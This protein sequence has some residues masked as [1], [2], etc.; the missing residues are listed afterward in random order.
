MTSFSV[1]SD[2]VIESARLNAVRQVMKTY[3]ARFKSV[4]EDISA[5][6]GIPEPVIIDT[7]LRRLM[8][9]LGEGHPGIIGKAGL[10]HFFYAIASLAW[11]AI[12][13]LVSVIYPK[14]RKII[15]V[16]LLLDY[17]GADNFIFYRAVLERLNPHKGA[18][19]SRKN[20]KVPGYPDE[21]N[22]IYRPVTGRFGRKAALQALFMLRK[23]FRHISLQD[24]SFAFLYVILVR[25]IARYKTDV[26]G[27]SASVFY[28]SGDNYFGGIRYWIYRNNGIGSIVLIQNALRGG[29]YSETYL[30]ADHYF[31][32]GRAIPGQIGLRAVRFYP[33][34][35]M[36]T[37]LT[38]MGP[39]RNEKKFDIVFIEQIVEVNYPETYNIW[40]YNAVLKNMVR[41]SREFPELKICFATRA[42]RENRQGVASAN[43]SLILGSPMMLSTEIGTTSYQAMMQSCLVV[44]YN[45]TMGF[46]AA[47]VGIPFI[48]CN[49]DRLA[50]LP[51]ED[52][53]SVLCDQSY[54]K[55]KERV[56]RLLNSGPE[57]T[58]YI[59]RMSDEYLAS[60]RDVPGE[61]AS[62]IN[63]LI[64]DGRT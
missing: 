64:I 22:I 57:L 23:I 34:G 25:K 54:D 44:T 52:D 50:F 2:L 11:L 58:Q 36:K 21:M 55:F 41:F 13:C 14:T 47:S 4:A 53:L 24:V 29:M 49:Y 30:Y 31:G 28:S 18:I 8:M 60:D 12:Q 32:F 27:L 42:G 43:E 46:E 5:D 40:A 63:G 16:D 20:G 62:V 9:D 17:W 15:K 35:S 56:W 37:W 33:I 39:E 48:Y 45:S 59:R 61:I 10:R 26:D 6:S 1:Y 51:P 19:F 7:I 38:K 3:E